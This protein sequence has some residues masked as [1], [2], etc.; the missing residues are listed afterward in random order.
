VEKFR[1]ITAYFRF[2]ELPPQRIYLA[3]WLFLCVVGESSEKTSAGWA[4][5]CLQA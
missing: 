5:G 2:L 1:I 4:F 3:F